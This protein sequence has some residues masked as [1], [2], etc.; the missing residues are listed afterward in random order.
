[1]YGDGM[2]VRDWLHVVGPRR[3]HRLRPAARRGRR[4]LQRGRARTAAAQPRGH[5]P[6]A[7]GRRARLVA[8]CAPC[9]T[10]PGHDRRYAMDGAKLAALGWTPRVAFEEGLPATVAW[11]RDHP[12]GWRAPGAATGT[13]TTSASTAR[14]C[15]AGRAV[16]PQSARRADRGAGRRHRG[17]RPARPRAGRGARGRAVHGDR[18]ARSAGTSPSSTSTRS[19]EASAGAFLD[20]ERPEVVIHTAA[21]TDVDGCARDPELAHAPQRHGRRR[22][23][24]RLRPARHRPGLHLDQRGLRRAAHRRH[25]LR[26]RRRSATR[27]TRTAPRRPRRERAGD[28]GVRGRRARAAAWASCGRRGSTAR[29]ATT[30]RPRSR[31]RPLRARD[32]GRAAAGR[33]G[34]DRR[35]DLHARP[36]RG[37]RGAARRGRDRRAP[38][39]LADPPPRQRAAARRAPTGPARSC[40]PRGSTSRSWTSRAA[41][42]S[43]PPR[44]RPGRCWSPRPCRPASRCATGGRRSPTPSRPCVRV[45]QQ[46]LTPDR[47]PDRQPAPSPTGATDRNRATGTALRPS[48]DGVRSRAQRG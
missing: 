26:A 45:A 37:H 28:R 40:A 44:R 25:R 36:R 43:A 22:A 14:G 34:R 6:P 16:E 48:R 10:G 41:P 27:S 32:A 19:T 8:W 21:W 35:A 47:A 46:G 20:A 31:P 7:G 11:Y 9:R 30:S 33:R 2:Q 17:Q 5:R 39:R 29:P 18:A 4:G 12:D 24:P 3:R 13:P 1:M 15:A 42:G 23:R 38:A